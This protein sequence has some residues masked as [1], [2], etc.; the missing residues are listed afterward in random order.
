MTTPKTPWRMPRATVALCV[1]AVAGPPGLAVAAPVV[2]TTSLVE[3]TS[4]V[5]RDDVTPPV[6]PTQRRLRFSAVTRG[7]AAGNRIVPPPRGSTD[8]P[9]VAGGTLSVANAA[10]SGEVVEV[11]LPASG[12]QTLG[13]AERPLGFVFRTPTSDAPVVLVRITADR[14]KVRIRGAGWT[15]TLDEAQPQEVLRGQRDLYANMNNQVLHL[16]NQG[17]TINQVQKVYEVP[18]S[19][20]Q[21]WFNRGYHGSPQH[22]SRGVIQRCVGS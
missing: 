12:W 21:Q 6:D 22:N 1:L 16:A 11:D 9:T 7:A 10:E 2:E 13:T 14:I 8:D 17:V 18:K 19:L 15:F 5:L 4:L 20:R 3:A